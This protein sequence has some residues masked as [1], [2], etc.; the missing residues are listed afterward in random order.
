MERKYTDSQEKAI[1]WDN[2]PVIVL[3]GPGSGKTAVLTNRIRR[4]LR[5]TSEESFRILALTFTNKAA[6]EMGER[7]SDGGINTEHRLYVGTFHSFCSEVLR[8][9]GSY[10]GINSDFDIYS[11][12]DDINFVIDNICERY[13]SIDWLFPAKELKLLSMIS[14]FEKKLCFT[15]EEIDAAMPKTEYAKAYKWIYR[16]YL[17]EMISNSTLDFDLLILMTYRLF[18]T[19]P[20]IA[21][22]YAKTYRYINV[23]EFQDTNYGQYKLITTM[24]GDKNRN[25]YIVADDDQVI[26]GWNGADHKRI[27]QF[28][29]SYNADLIQLNQNFRCPKAVIELANNLIK[30]NSGRARDKKPLEAMKIDTDANPHIFCNVFIDEREEVVSVTKII[31]KIREKNPED[32]ICVLARTNRLL[33]LA[34]QTTKDAG[35]N[36]ERSKKK[37]DFETPYV[38]WIFLLLKLANHRTDKKILSQLLGVMNDGLGIFVDED[39]I[40]L[41]SDLTDGDLL[42]A[43]RVKCIDAFQDDRFALSFS[44]NLI[45]GRNFLQFIDDA[46]VWSEEQIQKISDVSHRDQ[47]Y[48]EYEIEKKVWKEFQRHLQCNYEVKDMMLSTYMQEF[49]MTS[50]EEEPKQGAVQFLTIHAAKG[51]EFDHVILIGLVND[52]L[53]SYQSIK[54]GLD[55]IE[56]EE[57]RRNCFVAITRTK[58]ILYLTYAEKYFGWNKNQSIFLKEMF[59]K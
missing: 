23:D 55:S 29:E 13:K 56:M 9:H 57:E 28:K 43:I 38:L 6:Q 39:E 12:N 11:S 33:Q 21:N 15:E 30:H 40:L 59:S 10:V 45:E 50:K 47:M 5:E 52:E 8:N 27:I 58:K 2:G 7:I 1:N 35:I 18:I 24:C 41:E 26:Y 54:K 49:A 36:C 42:K 32:T 34:F 4:I 25:I 20:A 19:K 44:M 22:I 16:E 31:S 53:P 14:Y 17:N 51:K 3:A 46:F 37:A 48:Q